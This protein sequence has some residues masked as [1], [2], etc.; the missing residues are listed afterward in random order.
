VI[1]PKK[2]HVEELMNVGDAISPADIAIRKGENSANPHQNRNE[3]NLFAE[4]PSHEIQKE[5]KGIEDPK[6]DNE[7]KIASRVVSLF[8]RERIDQ[9]V[10]SPFAPRDIIRVTDR[11]AD[12]KDNGGSESVGKIDPE[13]F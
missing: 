2:K 4:G 1:I 7:P 10:E 13:E 11:I 5:I 6:I 8:H 9:E 3:V 12:K